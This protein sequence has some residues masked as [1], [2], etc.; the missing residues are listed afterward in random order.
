MNDF[1]KDPQQGV[2][3][4]MLSKLTN[5]TVAPEEA[6]LLKE[7]T[8]SESA[9]SNPDNAANND[10]IELDGDFD[11]EGYEVV[12]REFFGHTKEPSITLANYKVYVNAACLNRFQSVDYILP[13]VNARKKT[14]LFRPSHD[15]EHDAIPWCVPG[16]IQRKPRQITCK[17]FFVNLFAL[18][19]WNPNYRYKLLGKVIHAKNGYFITFDLTAA[20][21]YR[22]VPKDGGYLINSHTPLYHAGWQGQFGLPFEVHQESMRINIVDGYAVYA[23]KDNRVVPIKNT[24]EK[25]TYNLPDDAVYIEPAGGVM[26]NE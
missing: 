20:A 16:S 17:M 12:R 22:S 2:I 14:L 5:A 9:A 26:S 23:I 13:M 6:G 3:A 1:T 8:A 10:M 25:L 19:R 24:S 11:F 4:N 7:D 15:E 21:V 18:M